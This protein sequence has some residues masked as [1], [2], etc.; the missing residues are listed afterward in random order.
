MLFK[1]VKYRVSVEI[2]LGLF[3]RYVSFVTKFVV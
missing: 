1:G 3:L 2:V